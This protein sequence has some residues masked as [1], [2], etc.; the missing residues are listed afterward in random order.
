MFCA[1][2]GIESGQNGSFCQSCGKPLSASA[3]ISAPISAPSAPN[4]S[5]FQTNQP[6]FPL[7]FDAMTPPF[8]IASNAPRPMKFVEA[9]QYGYQNYAK[10]KGR[11]SRSEYWFWILHYY[12]GYIVLSIVSI[13]PSALIDGMP[14]L[15]FA[16][17]FIF[18]VF[19]PSIART[20]RRLHDINKPGSMM[21]LGLIPIVGSILLIVWLSKKGDVG[22]NT[23]GPGMSPAFQF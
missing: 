2:C 18:G 19:V 9:V 4:F 23:Y 5:S 20:T 14:T 3:P 16:A 7:G 17:I 15:P 11:A 1:N 8:M 21:L 12:L 6:A 10:F 22:A 13:I